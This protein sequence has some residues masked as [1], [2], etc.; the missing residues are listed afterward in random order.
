MKTPSPIYTLAPAG[1]PATGSRRIRTR[2]T[3]TSSSAHVLDVNPAPALLRTP[4]KMS[5][6]RSSVIVGPVPFWVI[7]RASEPIVTVA[8]RGETPEYAAT[9][10]LTT[11][12]V[13]PLAGE[14][15]VTNAAAVA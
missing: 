5:A 14:M 15:P 12:L 2:V 9:V 1:S 10:M 6:V 13:D 11:A 7:V 8:T 4:A 3:S